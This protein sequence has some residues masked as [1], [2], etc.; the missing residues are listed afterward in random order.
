MYCVIS[1]NG[2]DDRSLDSDKVFFVT[3]LRGRQFNCKSGS[4]KK[5]SSCDTGVVGRN[6]CPHIVQQNVI[7]EMSHYRIIE[8]TI[9]GL[10]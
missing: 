1:G 9:F 6:S 5:A 10:P 7:R 4:W 3:L 2:D 8:Y